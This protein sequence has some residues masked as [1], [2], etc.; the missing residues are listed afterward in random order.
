MALRARIHDAQARERLAQLQLE[1]DQAEA[2]AKEAR[3]RVEQA[4]RGR[5]DTS[6]DPSLLPDP[7]RARHDDLSTKIAEEGK[8]RVVDPKPFDGRDYG[9]YLVFIRACERVF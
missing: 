2:R 9:A 3:Q 1:A 5:S 7:K 8:R 6:N 4:T